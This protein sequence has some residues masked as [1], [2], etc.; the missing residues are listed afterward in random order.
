ML[1]TLA[2]ARQAYFKNTNVGMAD[3]SGQTPEP[4][5]DVTPAA[6]PSGAEAVAAEMNGR[7]STA[8]TGPRI[9]HQSQDR[10][11]SMTPDDES[12]ILKGRRNVRDEDGDAYFAWVA[13]AIRASNGR[14]PLFTIVRNAVQM[15][16]GRGSCVGCD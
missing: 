4:T 7:A 3:A 15:F 6:S 11:P 16:G 9:V 12:L 2:L 14:T 5:P 13:A 10:G 8:P 1:A